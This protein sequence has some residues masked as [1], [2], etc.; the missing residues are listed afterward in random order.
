MLAKKRKIG[1][2]RGF[3]YFYPV[4]SFEFYSSLSSL[5]SSE[6]NLADAAYIDSPKAKAKIPIIITDAIY[7]S[8]L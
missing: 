6:S 5:L 8:N 7:F 2:Y 4:A 1:G 3:P